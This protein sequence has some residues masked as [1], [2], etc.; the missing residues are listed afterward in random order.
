MSHASLS[1]GNSHIPMSRSQALSLAML[2]VIP[3][4][5][6]DALCIAKSYRYIALPSCED[7]IILCSFIVT[8]Y[9]TGV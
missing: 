8:Q 5:F 4:E 6:V 1:I 9:S 3:C 2:G 7:D